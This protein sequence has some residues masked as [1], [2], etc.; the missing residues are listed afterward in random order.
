MPNQTQTLSKGPGQFVIGQMPLF[1]Q[2]AKGCYVWDVDG[3]KYIDFIGGRWP[4]ILGYAHPITDNA[5]KKQ[6]KNGITFS[7]PHPLELE[8]AKLLIEII[9]SAEMVRFA[10]NGSDATGGAVRIARAYTKREIILYCGYHGAQDW[11]IITTERSAGVPKILKKL[12]HGF[13]Y[14]NIESL[15]KLFKKFKNKVAA[16]IMEPMY[17]QE[18]KDGFLRKV[19]KLAH[20]NGALLI[21]DEVI[22]GFRWSLGGAQ[23][24]FGVTPDLACF[25]K[26]MANGMPIS[27]IVGKKDVMQ[28]TEDVFLSMTY[29]GECLSLAAA[30]AV[31]IAMKNNPGILKHIWRM[32]T[33]LQNGI[34]VLITKHGLDDFAGCVGVPPTPVMHFKSAHGQNILALKA[35]FQ[36]YLMDRGIMYAAYWNIIYSHKPRHI[37]F[38]LRAADRAFAQLKEDIVKNRVSKKIKN[39]PQPVFKNV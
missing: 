10:K 20:K 23:K 15:E 21:F 24:Y 32:G 27:C 33:A 19:K 36:K 17:D 14:N 12:V 25:G 3:N 4:I 38:A 9:P 2:K 26:A 37:N 31:I 35:L 8:V 1:N 22:T 13:E 6:L 18:P 28:K 11:Y 7:Q 39:P 16:V 34:R 5:V 29:G 30:K